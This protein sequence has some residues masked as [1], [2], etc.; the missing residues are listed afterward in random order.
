MTTK[1][2][3]G[4]GNPGREYENTRHNIGF[5]ALERIAA[6][7][8]S[9]F[10]K[11]NATSRYAEEKSGVVLA[12]PTTFMNSSGA[13]VRELVSLFSITPQTDLLVILDDAD[14]PFGRL[15]FRK[16]GTSG[17]HRGLES[18]IQEIGTEDFS[19]LRIGVGRPADKASELKE[20]VL[21]PFS[22][23]EKDV[24][25]EIL[26]RAAEA[27]LMWRDQGAEPVMN[28]FNAP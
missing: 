18:V 25:P 23:E 22:G 10:R 24:L 6:K 28:R 3:V 1:L 9:A 12:A 16:K 7:T 13:A 20:F 11:K 4:L 21:D 8:G 5:L 17:G 14:L 27:S 26:E 2:I 19:R 15:R